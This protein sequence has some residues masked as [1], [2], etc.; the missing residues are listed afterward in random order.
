MRRSRQT[1]L[2][3]LVV[4][5]VGAW[6]AAS[7][8]G[9]ARP[10]VILLS[11][12]DG[13]NAPGLRALVSALEPAG[14]VFV[15]APFTDQ[16]GTGQS[17]TIGHAIV[18]HAE[19]APK[20]VVGYAIEAPPATCVRV[21]MDKLLPR[22]PDVV[23]SGINRGA[24]LG[25]TVYYSGTLGAAREAALSGIPAL[26][27]SLGGNQEQDYARAAAYVRRLLEQLRARG[28][29]KPGLFLNV[30]VP[31]GAPRGVRLA[32]LSLKEGQE[33]YRLLN[34]APGTQ[35]FLPAWQPPQHDT[36]GTDVQAFARGFITLTPMRLDVTAGG[37]FHALGALALPSLPADL[38]R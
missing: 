16:S 20:G 28:M 18:V 29:L 34:S 2:F 17:I 6:P 9:A 27:V 19:Q 36:E 13:Y 23:I 3:L 35:S 31:A 37:E 38:A 10:F 32:R 33:T 8:A 14:Q 12:D 25:A 11:N 24:N 21:G 5:L 22:R 15:S 7:P 1:A 26:A 30:N 4:I